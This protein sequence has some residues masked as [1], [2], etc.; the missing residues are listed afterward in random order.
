[1]MEGEFFFVEELELGGYDFV[2]VDEVFFD[3]KCLIC[4]VVMCNFV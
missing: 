1:M 4:F 2:F 3:K